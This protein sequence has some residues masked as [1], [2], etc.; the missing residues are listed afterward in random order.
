MT[1]E[2]L[3]HLLVKTEEYTQ[4]QV[5]DMSGYELLDAMLIWEGI[6]GYTRQILRW[7][8]KKPL[9]NPTITHNP[10]FQLHSPV[11]PNPLGEPV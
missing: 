1:K 9:T 8:K 7:A 11:L 10:T 3:K 5:D 2:E 6:C 4:E